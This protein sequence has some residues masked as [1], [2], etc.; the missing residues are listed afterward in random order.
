M[1]G[2]AT[3]CMFNNLCSNGTVYN[4]VDVYTPLTNSW[5]TLAPMQSPRYRFAAALYHGMI[6]A[7]GGSDGT[8]AVAS[9]EAYDPISDTWT[10]VASLPQI[11]EAPVAVVDG[12]DRL[13]VFGGFDGGPSS[14]S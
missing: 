7:I 10:T 14:Y 13:D 8:Q 2:G 1:L 11:D 9:V 3:Q 12:N 5:S 6:Y 4:R